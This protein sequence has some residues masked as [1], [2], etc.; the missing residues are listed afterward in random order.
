[1]FLTSILKRINS[2]EEGVIIAFRN[3]PKTESKELLASR[4]IKIRRGSKTPE[5]MTKG[6]R[7]LLELI[8]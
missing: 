2:E 4:K 3:K 6:A 1:M 8:K 7:R 5:E